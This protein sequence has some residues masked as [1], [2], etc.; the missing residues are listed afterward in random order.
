MEHPDALVQQGIALARAGQK[1]QAYS[2][3][4]RALFISGDDATLRI[5]LGATA[6][7][8]AESL[9]HLEQ[10][11][12]LEPYNPQ[13]QAGLQWVHQQ[14]SA[15]GAPPPPAAPSP[16]EPPRASGGLRRP[17]APSP[18]EPPPAPRSYGTSG[19]SQP[20]T[21]YEDSGYQTAPTHY[22]APPP[23]RMAARPL[24]MPGPEAPQQVGGAL[25]CANCGMRA[26]PGDRFCLR[27]GRP[28]PAGDTL[29]APATPTSS[30]PPRTGVITM[31]G[32]QEAADSSAPLD[33]SIAPQPRNLSFRPLEAE[34][35]PAVPPLP[36]EMGPP[37]TVLA[38]KRPKAAGSTGSGGGT[39][40]RLVMGGLVTLGVI[41][42]LTLVGVYVFAIRPAQQS[43]AD[44]TAV[45]I[46]ASNNATATVVATVT[47]GAIAQATA[48][49]QA[50]MVAAPTVTAQA[51]TE[52]YFGQI[53]TIL[54]QVTAQDADIEHTLEG[55]ENGTF[56]Y[57]VAASQFE[58]FV[59]DS[60]SVKSQLAQLSVPSEQRHHHQQ[61]TEALSARGQGIVAGQQYIEDLATAAFAIFQAQ[62]ADADLK[63]AQTACAATKAR[64]DCN[65][66]I[67]AQQ[68][69]DEASGIADRARTYAEQSFQDYNRNWQQYKQL[70]PTGPSGGDQQ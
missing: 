33:L 19:Y 62:K 54:Q 48:R 39:A 12:A 38:P 40:G 5:W 37:Q 66:V 22:A 28:L 14:M 30:T 34:A 26:N 27:C 9:T 17:F 36:Q 70:M 60:S 69:Y 56:G 24:D 47:Q 63:A 52:R 13:A 7:T 50:T 2:T 57:D 43:S 8:L 41:L 64:A 59:D 44:A 42:L 49:R 23:A 25:A 68:A 6:P 29:T 65:A 61:M 3:L 46:A 45:A 58:K 51:R 35:P 4:R 11:V 32:L 1:E 15:A 55:V 21:A 67:V 18:V 10:A 20:N 31:Q 53:A 16:N